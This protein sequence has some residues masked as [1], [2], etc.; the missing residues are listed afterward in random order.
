MNNTHRL[1]SKAVALLVVLLMAGSFL[2]LVP[3]EPARTVG[4]SLFTLPAGAYTP[5]FV[6]SNEVTLLSV[7]SQ[8]KTA[9]PG[10]SVPFAV[11]YNVHAGSNPSQVTQAFFVVSWTPSW[12]PPAGYY[13]PMYDGTPGLAPGV[14]QSQ[15]LTVI[16]PTVPGTYYIWFLMGSFYS[17]AD[18]VNAF[19][20]SPPL[21]AHLEV[22]VQ[23][24]TVP[25]GIATYVPITITNSQSSPTPAPFQQMVEVDSTTY[26]TYEAAN[27]QNVEFFD[28]SGNI[29]PS[30]LESGNSNTSTS[31]IYWLS[32]PNGIPGDSTVTVYMGFASTSAN[33]FNSVSTGEAP[34]LSSSYGQYDDGAQV[35]PYYWSFSGTSL[36]SGWTT[37]VACTGDSVTVD[38][39]VTYS[40][41][42]IYGCGVNVYTTGEYNPE[43][44]IV[45]YLTQSNCLSSCADA[46]TS[47]PGGAYAYGWSSTNV[48]PSDAANFAIWSG[49]WSY[50]EMV[51][52]VP[53]NTNWNILSSWG[54]ATEGCGSLDYSVAIVCSG[55]A[56][57]STTSSTIN[58]GG[59][60]VSLQ[61]GQVQWVHVRF[62]PPNGVMP[63]V[64]IGSTSTPSSESVSLFTACINGLVVDINGVASPG[65]SVTSITWNW[66]D[67]TSS[68]GYFPESHTY[69]SPGT[70]SVIATA[71][72]SDGT[73]ATSTPQSV[74]VGNGILT[75]CEALTISDL[76]GGGSV[77]Y[78]AS[79]GSGTVSSGNSATL[80]L[81]Y[82]DDLN[83]AANPEVGNSFWEWVASSGI[84]GLGST[85]VDT[86]AATTTIV[87]DTTS[88]I[89]PIFTS[90][91]TGYSSNWAGYAA[92]SP[93]ASNP[94]SVTGVQGTWK[95][96]QVSGAG[97]SSQWIGIGGYGSGT[98][99]IQIGTESDSYGLV[100]NYYS[101]SERYPMESQQGLCNFL[102][103]CNYPVSAG[104]VMYASITLADKTSNQWNMELDD[105][106]Q[107]WSYSTTTTFAPT[108]TTAEWIDEGT[109]ACL[110]QKYCALL[111][112]NFGTAE[113]G[114]DYF[115]SQSST[116]VSSTNFATIEE[117]SRQIS[118]LTYQELFMTSDGSSTGTPQANPSALSSDG[119]SFSVSYPPPPSPQPSP[120][121]CHCI[122]S[123][124]ISYSPMSSGS[125]SLS[126]AT[127]GI[128]IH[129]TGSSASDGTTL[130]MV[131]TTFSSQPTGTGPTSFSASDYFDVYLSGISDG[132]AS[133]CS[134]ALQ[135]PLSGAP[136][137]YYWDGTSWQPVSTA[138]EQGNSICGN[139]PVPA[140]SGTVVAVGF[141]AP[142]VSSTVPEFPFGMAL[143][144]GLAIP[145]LLLIRKKF[146]P[147][148]FE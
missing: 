75:N 47:V 113:F 87:V 24:Q 146:S 133:V 4:S 28:S 78:Q 92:F 127:T 118:G 122:A 10:E 44:V 54:T 61:T 39:G 100:Q 66:G 132:T 3:I 144:L 85:P 5:S 35:F 70:Y 93:E 115:T 46:D 34:E 19:S 80:H 138:S 48:S 94:S 76:L 69:S 8:S 32:L 116:K 21:P 139:I 36:P 6:I 112:P 130:A 59:R 33:L 56:Y 83:I 23:S 62:Q 124:S 88:A 114:G 110:A 18:A 86:T 72:Y 2:S 119:T 134:P 108:T 137:M 14:T 15:T 106:T 67:T 104:D 43:S 20:N 50:E 95:V 147:T 96:Q 26:S 145:A 109:S 105:L 90:S 63:S 102:S 27:L 42:G 38:N 129:V 128:T 89:Y 9:A 31:T 29:I 131:G 142:P 98:N 101:W 45:D 81:D 111:L 22:V 107:S 99:L 73:S 60:G 49:P 30:W 148:S 64:T 13:F 84:T 68:T 7:D 58:M 51:P 140:L 79:V 16:A 125:T 55:A 1:G 52:T 12:P 91:S 53:L 41:P 97:L 11:T 135:S 82:A 123:Q 25:S 37:F 141:A 77:T 71:H 143:L 57:V 17:M 74:T 136:F 126:Q 121:T 40:S 117:V 120:F 65:A 103:T